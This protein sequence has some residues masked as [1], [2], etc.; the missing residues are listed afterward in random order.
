M[1]T[2]PL[3]E[4]PVESLREEATK[5]RLTPDTLREFLRE[6]NV[7]EDKWP[8]L[9]AEVA[10]ANAL[11]DRILDF[12]D[13]LHE[14]REIAWDEFWQELNAIGE[15]HGCDCGIPF[16]VLTS[17]G[18][19]DEYPL[20]LANR[21]PLQIVA[22]NQ[23][24]AS[25]E[26]EDRLQRTLRF[27]TRNSWHRVGDVT[28]CVVDTEQGSYAYPEWH[29]GVRLRKIMA[30]MEVRTS[31]QHSVEAEEKA[32]Q[33]L[34]SKINEQQYKTYFL[35]G[36]FVERSVRSDIYYMFRKGKPTLALSFHGDRNKGGRVIAALCMHPMG[37]YAYTHVGLM[38]PTDEV[39]A[40]LLMM[41][42]SEHKF[43]AKSGQWSAWDVRSGI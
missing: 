28:W 11:Q 32:L 29:A 8:E 16:P 37:Y 20:V 38:C 21:S 31:T 24:V 5:G 40:A 14:G 9:I 6:R 23:R 18:R 43:W 19:N 4:Q 10:L 1:A 2:A 3:P 41:R 25:T 34:R 12:A 30:A 39:I 33:S 42:G 26:A 27:R 15:D 22:A 13:A 7:P 17:Q 36:D 35:N